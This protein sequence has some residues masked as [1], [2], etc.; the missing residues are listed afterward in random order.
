MLTEN[1]KE[2]ITDCWNDFNDSKSNESSSILV[3]PSIPILWFGDLAKYRDS[4][5]R[6][7]TVGLNP[8]NLEFS[9]KQNCNHEISLRFNKAMSCNNLTADSEINNY[10]EAMND[11]FKQNPYKKWF[12]S[13]EKVLNQLQSSYYEDEIDF[14]NRAI[15]LDIYAPIAT[16]PTW[17][18]LAVDKKKCLSCF[19]AYFSH[20]IKE[21]KP[22]IV[23]ISANVG[24]IKE[25]FGVVKCNAEYKS[26]RIDGKRAFIDAYDSCSIDGVVLISGLNMS[27]TPFG[28]MKKEFIETNMLAIKEK[29]N[30]QI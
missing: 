10:Y 2:I 4:R 6:I 1:L 24:I 11:Y 18:K 8:S 29:M 23:L 30:I 15:H 17:G 27:G 3:N 13:F 5:K 14:A 19:K 25:V 26:K 12:N 28:G 22:E 20:L 21:L 7:I 9:T 16:N